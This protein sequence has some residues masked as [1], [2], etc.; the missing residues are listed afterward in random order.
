MVLTIRPSAH[1]AISST[2]AIYTLFGSKQELVRASYAY[3]R[4]PEG[5]LL[6]H[7]PESGQLLGHFSEYSELQQGQ[8]S[9]MRGT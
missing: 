8:I 1:T 4:I 7:F 5:V 6:G 3:P 9:R 2:P